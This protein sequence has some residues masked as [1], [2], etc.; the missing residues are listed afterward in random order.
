MPIHN[1]LTFPLI[2]TIALVSVVLSM[3]AARGSRGPWFLP[4]WSRKRDSFTEAGWRYRT[5]SIWCGYLIISIAT[6]DQLF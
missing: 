2:M 1:R 6:A 4:L 5:W 3:L